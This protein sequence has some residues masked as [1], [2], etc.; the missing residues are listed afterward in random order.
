MAKASGWN[1]EPDFVDHGASTGIEILPTPESD[2]CPELTHFALDLGDL[3]AMLEIR[4]DV[5]ISPKTPEKW[6][7]W[8]RIEARLAPDFV[9]KLKKEIHV[10][11]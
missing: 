5:V 10:K 4:H 11:G 9:E 6:R 1:M 8:K 3:Y 7:L 2:C